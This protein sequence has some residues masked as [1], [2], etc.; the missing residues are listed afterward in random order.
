MSTAIFLCTLLTSPGLADDRIAE[1]ASEDIS[2]ADRDA[3]VEELKRSDI[4]TTAPPILKLLRDYASPEEPGI[5]PKPWMNDRHSHRA[6]V[7]YAAAAVWDTLFDGK[8]DLAKVAILLKLLNDYSDTY[9]RYVVLEKL[10]IHWSSDAEKQVADLLQRRE[11]QDATKLDALRV[12]LEQVGE[13][14]VPHAIDFIRSAPDK[15]KS[16]RYE[17]LFNVGDRFFKYARKNQD[18]IVTLGFAILEA[19]ATPG[20]SAGYFLARQLGFFLKVSREFA[21]DQRA[22]QY[23]G[24]SGLD[25]SFFADTVMNAL[26]WRKKSPAGVVTTP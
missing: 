19:D 22:P 5:G 6:K 11:T 20:T 12:L 8:S 18:E 23:Q 7:W 26:A 14:Y 3:L 25:E 10:R 15:D 16:R 9:S 13:Q 1:L 17:R 24:K 4:S 21:P 2:N